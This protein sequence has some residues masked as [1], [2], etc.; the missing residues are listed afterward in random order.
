[1]GR[2]DDIARSAGNVPN[3]L[4]VNVAALD[5]LLPLMDGQ[6][7]LAAQLHAARLGSLAAFARARADQ[8]TLELG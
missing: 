7:W 5:R 1:M 8:I 6:F 4:A 3:R 2:H